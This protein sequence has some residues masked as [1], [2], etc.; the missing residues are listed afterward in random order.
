M[1]A[2]TP[3]Q[4]QGLF[5]GSVMGSDNKRRAP[6]SDTC[7]SKGVGSVMTAITL[8]PQIKFPSLGPL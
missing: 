4:T 3:A 5:Q 6:P 8:L 1:K 2:P 7:F